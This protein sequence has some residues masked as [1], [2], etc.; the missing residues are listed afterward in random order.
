MKIQLQPV[1]GVVP[2]ETD[3]LEVVGVFPPRFEELAWATVWP[4]SGVVRRADGRVETETIWVDRHL[5][6]CGDFHSKWSWLPRRRRGR[7]F[8]L[9]LFWSSGYYHWICDVLARLHPVLPRLAPDVQVILP[10]NLKPWQ[11]RSLEL[12]GL[13]PN[14]WLPYAG[15]RPWRVEKLVYASPVAMTGDHEEKSLCWLRDTIWQHCLGGPPARPGWRKLYLT[16]KD[17]WSRN[18]V[19]EAELLPLLTQRGFEAVDC[20]ALTFDQQVRL[21][22]EAALVAGP[23]GASFTNLLWTPPGADVFEVFEPAS[24]RRCYWSMCRTLGHRHHCGIARPVAQDQKEAN[25]RIPVDEFLHAL[26]NVSNR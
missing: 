18:V 16:R 6:Q 25:L 8:N 14:Q 12:A 5:A 4:G 3:N 11:A 10:P 20:G 24:V 21:F 13:P 15:K 1:F 9:S 19:N 17:T 7:Y 2:A 23:H 26:E 22:A